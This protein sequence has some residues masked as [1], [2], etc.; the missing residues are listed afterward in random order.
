MTNRQVSNCNN[1]LPLPFK[2]HLLETSSVEIFDVFHVHIMV[3]IG[4]ILLSGQRYLVEYFCMRQSYPQTSELSLEGKRGK[5]YFLGPGAQRKDSR[6]RIKNKKLSN[7]ND[8]N[9]LLFYLVFILCLNW[10]NLRTPACSIAYCSTWYLFYASTGTTYALRLAALLTVLLVIYLPQLAQKPYLT[11]SGLQ[12][13]LLF[14]L[15]F[16]LYLN[17]HKKLT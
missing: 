7:F 3:I 4:K 12:H 1:F 17:W 2:S 16:I 6:F 13:C 8:D 9:C 14:Y 10:H 15:L 11:H 5:N